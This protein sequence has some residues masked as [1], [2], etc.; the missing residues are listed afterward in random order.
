MAVQISGKQIKWGIIA[1]GKTLAD[2]I[3]EGIVQD[4]QLSRGGNVE[5]IPDED[6]DMVTRV[7]HGAMNTGT[8]NTTVTAVSPSLPAKGDEITGATAIDGVDL[9]TGRI[10]V[11][12]ASITYS[13]VA[14]TRVAISFA[15]YPD[16]PADD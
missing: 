12:E 5:N 10:F 15:H 13:G 6:G 8:I 4:I 2:G 1:A 9:S 7:D 11:E 3:V 14:A 16:M